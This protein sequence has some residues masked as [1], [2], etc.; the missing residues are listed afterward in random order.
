MAVE[1]CQELQM[2]G[3]GTNQFER[4]NLHP[5]LQNEDFNEEKICFG[6]EGIY[7]DSWVRRRTYDAFKEVLGSGVRY[8]LQV[9]KGL[10]ENSDGGCVV[11]MQ[12]RLALLQQ[13]TFL[14]TLCGGASLNRFN[15]LHDL[16]STKV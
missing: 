1:R 15:T 6:V 14:Q 11:G 16:K 4:H 12:T 13:V 8:H 7:I 9:R 10:H 2:T 3:T 5:P